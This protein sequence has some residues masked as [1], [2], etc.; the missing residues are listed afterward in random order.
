MTQL[1]N[2][3]FKI[4]LKY[5]TEVN[6]QMYFDHPKSRNLKT[7]GNFE[8]EQITSGTYYVCVVYWETSALNTASV[9]VPGQNKSH[10]HIM[11]V[12]PP[13]AQYQLG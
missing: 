9:F 6:L 8:A 11:S 13:F 12:T 4:T 7:K 10:I 2:E 1:K 3:Y 5:N